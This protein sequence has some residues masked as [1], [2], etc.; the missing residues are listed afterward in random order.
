MKRK[1]QCD[2][3]NK[4]FST[5]SNLQTHKRMHTGEK[6]YSCH[7]CDKAFS[8]SSHLH[9]H[10]RIHTGEKPYSCDQCDK[11]FSTRSHLQVHKRTHTG[12][13]PYSCDHCPK[14]FNESSTRSKHHKMHEEQKKYQ[15]VCEMQDGGLQKASE[16]DIQCTIRCKT[17]RDLEYHIQR[18]HTQEGIAKKFHSETKLAE[19]F[20]SKGIRYERDWMNFLSFKNCKNIEGGKQSA[21]PDFYL[22]GKTAELG[23]IFLVGND[24]FAH[25]QTKCE[26]QRMYNITQALQDA[27]GFKDIPIVYVRFNPHFYRVDGKFYDLPLDKAHQILLEKIN[28]IQKKD[29][30]PG[31]NLMYINYDM[32]DGKLCI[33][34]DGEDDDYSRLFRDTILQ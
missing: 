6:P 12:E 2:E 22:L 10:K 4:A 18:H 20:D 3:C 27:D 9:T 24:E 16:K 17:Q 19:F 25:R 31:M 26:F 1:H 5:S 29:I 23:C 8:T 30:K 13:K 28:S 32:Q 21:R 14:K 11:A 33:F 7:Q 15:F 34:E